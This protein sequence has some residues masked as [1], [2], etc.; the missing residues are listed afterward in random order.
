MFHENLRLKPS[1][2]VHIQKKRK[3]CILKGSRNFTEKLE[4]PWT[5]EAD[6]KRANKSGSINAPR[7]CGCPSPDGKS[8]Q[9]TLKAAQSQSIWLQSNFVLTDCGVRSF[10]VEVEELPAARR[11][12][13]CSAS[14]EA[15][16]WSALLVPP[17]ISPR[18]PPKPSDP[19]PLPGV[20]RAGVLWILAWIHS[21]SLITHFTT[22]NRVRWVVA[23]WNVYFH[24]CFPCKRRY[25]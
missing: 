1:A 20:H 3:R 13:T 22:P 8:P 14:A 9:A 5:I 6:D 18:S 19:F 21:F 4:F 2:D 10:P 23:D 17:S 16:I 12:C 11:C 15:A 25:I 7:L 24:V